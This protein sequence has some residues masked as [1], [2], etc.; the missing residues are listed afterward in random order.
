MP[1]PARLGDPDRWSEEAWE[2][3]AEEYRRRRAPDALRQRVIAAIRAA[4]AAA[5]WQE[6][7]DAGETGRERDTTRALRRGC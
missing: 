2:R 5:S 4:A 6:L 7:L 3:F 1:P